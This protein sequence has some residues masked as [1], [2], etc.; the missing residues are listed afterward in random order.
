MLV[1]VGVEVGVR[2][3]AE[4]EAWAGFSLGDKAEE[5][6]A[7]FIVGLCTVGRTRRVGLAAGESSSRSEVSIT[8]LE[9][10]GASGGFGVGVRRPELRELRRKILAL[11]VMSSL[12]VIVS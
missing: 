2:D 10:G 4:A 3:G 8:D 5:V 11:L 9:F 12:M 7:G 6:G 1:G